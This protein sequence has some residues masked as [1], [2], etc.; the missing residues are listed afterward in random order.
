MGG[1]RIYILSTAAVLVCG[2][3]AMLPMA[4]LGSSAIESSYREYAVRDMTANVKLFAQT[5]GTVL[6]RN[7]DAD[8]DGLFREARERSFTRFTLVARDGRV[9]AESD[10]DPARMENH[11]NRPE[12]AKA[13]TGKD[14]SDIRKSPTFGDDWIYIAVPFRDGALRAADSL[15]E[16]DLRLAQWWRLALKGLA[17]SLAILVCLAFLAARLI[18]R[19][20]EAAARG[21][22]RFAQGEFQHRL[23]P[24]GSSETRRLASA[25][26]DMAEELDGRFKLITRQREEMKTVFA[27]MTEG[28]VAVDPKG[29]I[30]L[31]NPAAEKLLGIGKRESVRVVEGAV[32]Q[33]ELLALLNATDTAA[34]EPVEREIRLAAGPD[35]DLSVLVHAARM[36]SGGRELGVLAV[37]R[38]VTQLRK[39]ETMRRDFVANVSHE[40][41]TPVT[42]MQSCLETLLDGG[43]DDPEHAGEFLSMALRNA[44]RMASIIGN[45]LLLAE[46]ESGGGENGRTTREPVRPAIDEALDLRREAAQARGVT[47]EAD[48]PAGLQAVVNQ[49]LLVH[50]LV[51]LVDNAIKYGPAGGVV[52]VK[53]SGDGDR[54]RIGVTD[55][56]PGIAP[57]HQARV[58]ERFYRV[59]GS[60]RRGEGSGLGL[61]ITRHIALAMDG[62]VE[63]SSGLGSGST[64]TIVLKK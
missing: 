61:A 37:L 54:V 56:G 50:A 23:T 53:A 44:R 39:L 5:I 57:R 59:D 10:D 35:K 7:P 47:L 3:A 33:P 46:M 1:I 30:M 41:R 6:E 49:R 26:N 18:S 12:V 34:D 31:M 25:L 13:L 38:D 22:E 20:I 4:W 19:P 9:L 36:R 17:L 62:D 40:L 28:V 52:R 48:C 60:A 42:S 8:L 43:I 21:A 29:R 14:G 32:R 2:L 51:N 11:L 27:S 16:V 55:Q 15:A 58:F 64:F 63:L 24:A 45:L